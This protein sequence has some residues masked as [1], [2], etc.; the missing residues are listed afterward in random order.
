MTK[1]NISRWTV[2]G[3]VRKYRWQIV[4]STLLVIMGGGIGYCRL[5]PMSLP[6]ISV[7][8]DAYAER[9]QYRPALRLREGRELLLVAIVSSNCYWSNLPETIQA[10]RSAK[11][12]LANQAATNEMGFAAMGVAR[13]MVAASGIEH[14][15]RHGAFDEVISG[16]SWINS[17]VLQFIYND[18]IPGF[19]GTPQVVVLEQTVLFEGGSRRITGRRELERKLGPTEIAAWVDAGAPLDFD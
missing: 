18:E 3:T 11:Q 9:R 2:I 7:A 12:L 17:G 14:L 16:R 6:R 1:N 13:D 5:L 15:A 19:A 4:A 8:W 10:V